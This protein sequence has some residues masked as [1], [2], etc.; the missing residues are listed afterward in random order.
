MKTLITAVALVALATT[1]FAQTANVVTPASTMKS[2]EKDMT[3]Q[4]D[5]DMKQADKDMKPST[6][7]SSTTTTTPMATSTPA[8]TSATMAEPTKKRIRE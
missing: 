8:S 1:A 5:K 6:S 3:K 4:A 2:G 7:T